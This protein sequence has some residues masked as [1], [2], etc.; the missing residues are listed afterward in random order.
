[1]T[2]MASLGGAE[3]GGRGEPRIGVGAWST[4]PEKA[5]GT[6]VTRGGCAPHPPLTIIAAVSQRHERYWRSK[7][8][9]GVSRGAGH[10]H[11]SVDTSNAP[12]TAGICPSRA[13]IA[14]PIKQ[15]AR[16]TGATFEYLLPPAKSEA[17][18]NP[19][20]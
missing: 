10:Q 15:A 5:A 11:M 12:A 14:R 6:G 20:A 1:M 17:H 9:A 13:R 7:C 3:R 8:I 2:I 4:A 19:T 18:F 16:S